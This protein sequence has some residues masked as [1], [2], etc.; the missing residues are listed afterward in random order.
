M[1]PRRLVHT[2]LLGRDLHL[3]EMQNDILILF[4][5]V[6]MS[7]E[8]KSRADILRWLLDVPGERYRDY[9]CKIYRYFAAMYM[10]YFCL[11]YIGNVYLDE[12][13]FHIAGQDERAQELIWKAMDWENFTMS[14]SYSEQ[15]SI[16][17]VFED[18]MTRFTL[19]TEDYIESTEEEA[20]N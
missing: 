8:R 3:P 9:S 20:A 5:N 12:Y 10:K 13:G 7:T 2:W 11:E 14:H 6:L 16:E 17:S 15:W 18:A 19:K 1:E 4:H